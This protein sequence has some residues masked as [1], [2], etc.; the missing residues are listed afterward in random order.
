[1]KFIV[2]S[3]LLISSSFAET[4][5][6]GKN[7]ASEILL[8]KSV[9]IS[10]QNCIKECRAKSLVSN[11]SVKFKKPT[12]SAHM[13]NPTSYLCK[14]LAGKPEIGIMK[15]NAEVSVCLFED[16]S[17]LFLWDFARKILD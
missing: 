13:N 10:K 17:F 11:P 9:R 16:N 15:N 1:M 14:Q 3:V 6:I 5:S 2:F 12:S 4:V 7:K 8:F